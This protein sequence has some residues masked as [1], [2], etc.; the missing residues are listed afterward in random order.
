[1]QSPTLFF[2]DLETS[3]ISSRTGRIMQFG[4]Q[5]TDLDLNPIGEPYNILIKLNEDVLPEPD[6]ILITGITP[7]KTLAEGITEAEFFKIFTN[8]IVQSSTVF[9]GFNSIRFDDEFMRFGLYRNFYDPYEWQWKDQCSRWDLLDVVRMTRALRPEGIQWPFEESTGQ[10][11]NRLELLTSANKLDHVDAHDALSDVRASIELAKLI[12]QKQPKLFD[13][14]FLMRNKKSVNELV[15]SGRPFVYSSGKYANE[16]EKTTIAYSL[17]PHPDRQGALVYDLRVDPQPF[18]KLSPQELAEAWK[19][20]K[21]RTTAQLPVKS[22]Q[23]NRC[24]AVAPIGVLRPEDLQRLGLDL[25]KTAEHKKI[26]DSA[27]T[28]I[29]S[30]GAALEILNKDREKA[31]TPVAASLVDSRLYEGFITDSDKR[32]F[33]KLHSA[34]PE[35]ISSFIDEFK[36]DRLKTLLPLYKARNFPKALTESEIE[37]WQEHKTKKLSESLPKFTERIEALASQKQLS[38]DDEYLLEELRLYVAS[39]I[40]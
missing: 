15:G 17:G 33:P 9:A 34:S 35:V 12:K 2:Y 3:G 7:Q 21:D 29:T 31:A 18:L 5:R 1:M 26:L 40:T 23:Y 10:P 11:S 36:D 8:E 38:K 25:D 27:P 19:Y 20:K 28:F 16:F 4:G 37:V 39:I 6:A 24:P 32:L 22:L 30:L 14:L 13:Y